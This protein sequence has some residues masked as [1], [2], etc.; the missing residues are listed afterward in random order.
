[1]PQVTNM[2]LPSLLRIWLVFKIVADLK[3]GEI[4]CTQIVNNFLSSQKIKLL[5][6]GVFVLNGVV[7]VVKL[8][9]WAHVHT[10]S[11]P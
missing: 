11:N 2:S 1:M 6:F 10:A 5:T 8:P 7:Y 9:S 3:V 4:S